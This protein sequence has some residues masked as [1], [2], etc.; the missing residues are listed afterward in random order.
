MNL[1][2][3]ARLQNLLGI[4][5]AAMD[6]IVALLLSKVPAFRTETAS[7]QSLAHYRLGEGRAMLNAA[8]AGLFA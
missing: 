7:K 2:A 6:D 8:R 5:R 4:A 3:I 1:A